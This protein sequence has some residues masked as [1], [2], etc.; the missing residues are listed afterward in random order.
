MN[1][2]NC[3][4]KLESNGTFQFEDVMCYTQ[5]STKM[6]CPNDKCDCHIY[7]M[8]W[9]SMGEFFS[10]INYDKTREVFPDS[11]YAAINS[12]AKKQEI[13]I[14]K[15]GLKEQ[16]YLS[17]WFTLGFLKPFIEF[18]YQGNEAGEVLKR[19]WRIKYLK[20]DK[21][22]HYRILYMSTFHMLKYKFRNWIENKKQW[23]ESPT[24]FSKRLVLK[25]FLPLED[26]QKKDRYR[27]IF[28]WY[29]N[30]FESRFKNKVIAVEFPKKTRK[31]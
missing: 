23:K 26:W 12:F 10:G 15:N 11:R 16:I 27:T 4:S 1:C 2:P 8:F 6:M 17:Q 5:T 9:D 31:S 25:H 14:S 3:L 21:S 13:E 18:N 20:K 30:T 24:S 19:T 22:G 28:K 7:E 29:I